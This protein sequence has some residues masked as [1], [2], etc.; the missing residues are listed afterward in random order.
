MILCVVETQIL[1]TW[2]EGT[3]RTLGYHGCYAVVSDGQSRG[4]GVFWKE[5]VEFNL[6]RYSQ[7]HIDRESRMNGK[8]A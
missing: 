3:T 2:V 5:L 8:P 7:R 4:L 6:L 1:K